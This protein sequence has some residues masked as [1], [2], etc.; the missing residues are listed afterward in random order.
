[1]YKNILTNLKDA[2]SSKIY[3]NFYD[4]G[5]ILIVCIICK[6][7]PVPMPRSTDNP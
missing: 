5:A 2:I 3:V 6:F 4:S 7:I 1:M